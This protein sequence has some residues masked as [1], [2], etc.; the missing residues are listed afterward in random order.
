MGWTR[1]SRLMADVKKAL[2]AKSAAAVLTSSG[3][4][5]PSGYLLFGNDERPKIEAGPQE[6]MRVLGQRWK[7]LGPAGQKPYNDQ[8]LKMKT[9]A[10]TGEKEQEP[11]MRVK[12]DAKIAKLAS[13]ASLAA[14]KGFFSGLTELTKDELNDKGKSINIM[15][16]TTLK[17]V[18]KDDGNF[19]VTFTPPKPADDS[20]TP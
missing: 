7:Q 10:S 1:T 3:N 2:L 14:I 12:G 17:V 11:V 5:G 8:A 20:T 15:K 16:G 4:R 19:E 13:D 18:R 9:E 6:K